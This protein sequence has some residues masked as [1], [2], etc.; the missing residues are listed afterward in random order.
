VLGWLLARS[1]LGWVALIII[2]ALRAVALAPSY[3]TSPE[4]WQAATAYVT[5][6]E[7]PGDC[8]AFYPLDARMPFAYYAHEPVRP[9]VERYETPRLPSGCHRVWLVV[10]HQ[11]LPNGTATARAHFSR[12]VALRTSLTRRY[13][14]HA[15]RAFGYASVIWVE[16][17][18]GP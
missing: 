2:V 4:N 15:V 10:S 13:A 8:L 7:R 14:R 11:G 9:Y 3:G 1:P 16:L 12:Y 5:A 6:A 18:S 17:F